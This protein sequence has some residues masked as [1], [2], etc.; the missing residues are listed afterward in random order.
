MDRKD[1]CSCG[2]VKWLL[3]ITFITAGV[4]IALLTLF[5]YYSIH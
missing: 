1:E 3:A 5:A 2:T 4:W